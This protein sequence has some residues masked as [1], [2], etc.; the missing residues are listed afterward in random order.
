MGRRWGGGDLETRDERGAVIRDPRL[1]PQRPT[2]TPLGAWRLGVSLARDSH[3]MTQARY[4]SQTGEATW[5]KPSHMHEESSRAAL[6]SPL[7][8]RAKRSAL[9]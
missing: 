9:V 7:A 4:T 8:L 2:A 6:L 5:H 1:R 3:G